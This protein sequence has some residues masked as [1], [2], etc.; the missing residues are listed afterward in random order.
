MKRIF[1]VLTLT[2]IAIGF[3]LTSCDDL[4]FL[5]GADELTEAEII[6]GLRQALVVGTDTAV[7]RLNKTD[8]YYADEAVKILLPAEAQPVYDI[9][10]RLPSSIVEDNILAINRAAEDAAKEAAPIFVDA[11]ADLTIADGL[12]ILQGEDTAA[13]SYLRANTRQ[14]LFDAFQPKIDVSLSKDLV[15]GLSANELYSNM[16]SLYNRASLNGFLFDEITT[17][18]LSVHTTNRA[19]QGLF[20]KVGDEERLIRTDVSHRVTDLLEKVFAEQD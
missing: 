7:A 6:A 16:I 20:M 19:L 18:S 4:P 8:G 5:D 3:T 13:T 15:L 12:G 9:L 14:K 17:N 2:W 11:I 1:K 10:D